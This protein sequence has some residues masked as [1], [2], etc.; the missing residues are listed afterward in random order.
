MKQRARVSVRCMMQGQEEK[1]PGKEERGMQ[2]QWG[3]KH[4]CGQRGLHLS[5]RV[6]R[7]HRFLSQASVSTQVTKLEK[8]SWSREKALL[9]LKL[10]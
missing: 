6:S 5:L 1:H 7:L 10:T 4:S 3:E 8:H 2:V 9:M